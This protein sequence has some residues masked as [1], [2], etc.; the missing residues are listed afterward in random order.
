MWW[1]KAQNKCNFVRNIG[2]KMKKSEKKKPAKNIELNK[3]QAR[4]EFGKRM[5]DFEVVL[6]DAKKKTI[7][8]KK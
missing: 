7:Q 8:K 4:I 5:N 3:E 6:I 2:Q 1:Y